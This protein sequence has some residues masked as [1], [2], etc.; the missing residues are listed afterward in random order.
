MTSFNP[1]AFPGRELAGCAQVFY[2]RPGVRQVANTVT[3][4]G[5]GHA[6][7]QITRDPE[8]AYIVF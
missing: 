5:I 4:F 7:E 3:I 6:R 8:D 1:E 2:N